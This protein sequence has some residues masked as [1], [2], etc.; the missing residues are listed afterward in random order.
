MTFPLA[1]KSAAPLL[2]MLKLHDKVYLFLLLHSSFAINA[3][4]K[5]LLGLNTTF[6]FFE[7]LKNPQPLGL[8][9]IT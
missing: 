5:D 4:G 1:C 8:R 9:Q 2:W 7:C 3:L 6:F